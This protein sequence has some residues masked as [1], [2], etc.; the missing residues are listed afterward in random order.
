MK[1]I[2]NSIDLD[3]EPIS[4]LTHLIGLV[5]AIVSLVFMIIL[6]ALDG[7]VM[8]II[9]FSIFGASLVLLYTSSFFYHIFPKQTLAKEVFQRIDH[10]M[11]FFLIAGS[12]TPICLTIDNRQA[13]WGLLITIWSISMVGIVIKSIG[14]KIKPWKSTLIY[15]LLGLL[16][17]TAIYPIS[18]WLSAEAML[19]LFGGGGLYIIGA[20]FYIIEDYV[21]RKRKF[22]M[23][24]IWH[25]FVM[26]G[27]FSHVYL[28]IR[29]IL[30]L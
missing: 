24:E 21:P 11:I 8:H 25:L 23:H 12:Y 13:G 20:I 17:F 18:Q 27:S 29:F 9:G 26:L 15:I 22:D 10:A 19:W 14:I 1:N 28:M 16:L 2:F 6:S 4:A 7:T 30:Y 3:N 5:V